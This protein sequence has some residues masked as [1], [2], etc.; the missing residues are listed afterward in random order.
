MK[1]LIIHNFLRQ[2]PPAGRRLR[3]LQRPLRRRASSPTARGSTS[4]SKRS[5][6]LVTALNPH[7]GYDNAA[8]IAKH[9]HAEGDHAPRV[10]ARA[11]S[12]SPPSSSTTGSDPRIWWGGRRDQGL[13]LEDSGSASRVTV[14]PGSG[15]S[16]RRNFDGSMA[17]RPDDRGNA[18]RDGGDGLGADPLQAPPGGDRGDP[19]CTAAAAGRAEPNPRHHAAGPVQALS[20]DRGAGPAGAPDRGRPDRSAAGRLA[21]AHAHRRPLGPAP[22]RFPGAS[23]R[24]SRWRHDPFSDLVA[25]RPSDRVRA[26]RARWCRTLDRRR[27]DR[28]GRGHRGRSDQ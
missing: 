20:L 28:P 13:G 21:A 26:G 10:G 16:S 12:C 1:P 15:F 4:C 23:D 3:E 17:H 2:R 9:A 8:K 22:G 24:A 25:R 11:R 19:R 18:G 27:R 14:G 7:I 6:M 5:L